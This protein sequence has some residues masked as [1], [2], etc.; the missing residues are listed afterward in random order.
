MWRERTSC[1]RT[2]IAY[3]GEESLKVVCVFEST[4]RI[5]SIDE[6]T[7]AEFFVIENAKLSLISKTTGEQLKI[8]KVGQT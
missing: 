3:G 5:P 2:F 1:D 4:L 6:Q 7:T 8:L